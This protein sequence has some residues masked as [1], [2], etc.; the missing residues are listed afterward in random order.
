[1]DKETG[2]KENSFFG[3]RASKL[4]AMLLLVAAVCYALAQCVLNGLWFVALG[5]AALTVCAAFGVLLIYFSLRMAR[6]K[7]FDITVDTT[8]Q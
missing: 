4:I 8:R 3:Q 5:V 2:I 6:R 1:M 7:S